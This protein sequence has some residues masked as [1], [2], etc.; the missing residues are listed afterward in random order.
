MCSMLA[1]LE[2]DCGVTMN[3]IKLW[4]GNSLYRAQ[5]ISVHAPSGGVPHEI[6]K[7]N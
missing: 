1:A 5:P 6:T 7:V 3:I 4:I 2:I